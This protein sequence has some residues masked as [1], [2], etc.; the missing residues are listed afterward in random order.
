M[1]EV[2]LHAGILDYPAHESFELTMVF[3]WRR[4]EGVLE[5]ATETSWHDVR[6]RR[7]RWCAYFGGGRFP[8]L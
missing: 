2:T 8:S 5:K 1:Y 6:D 3:F 7:R 4:G